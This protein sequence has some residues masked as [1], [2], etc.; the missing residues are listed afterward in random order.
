MRLT[1]RRQ[2]MEQIEICGRDRRSRPCALSFV[3]VSSGK[4]QLAHF[5]ITVEASPGA[6]TCTRDTGKGTCSSH[7]KTSSVGTQHRS[8]FVIFQRTCGHCITVGE[9]APNQ[10]FALIRRRWSVVLHLQFP[11]CTSFALGLVPDCRLG[12]FLEILVLLSKG[13]A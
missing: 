6:H 3:G 4:C 13:L 7:V 9:V 8:L 5:F 11:G 1:T 12:V 10:C 2:G